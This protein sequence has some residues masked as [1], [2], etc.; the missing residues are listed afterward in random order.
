MRKGNYEE[1]WT[2][3]SGVGVYVW[4]QVLG[5]HRGRKRLWIGPVSLNPLAN[6]G[7]GP[8]VTQNVLALF[9]RVL[10]FLLSIHF[11][12]IPLLE[13]KNPL[14]SKVAFLLQS[15]KTLTRH[16]SCSYSPMFDLIAFPPLC[17]TAPPARL[18]QTVLEAGEEGNVILT[19]RRGDK[20]DLTHAHLAGFPMVLKG[21]GTGWLGIA[22]VMSLLPEVLGLKGPPQGKGKLESSQEY[23]N[24]IIIQVFF[25]LLALKLMS[26]LTKIQKWSF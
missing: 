20:V 15:R 8:P 21:L 17:A 1:T 4:P 6:S 26:S 25:S 9:W 7:I 2:R 19:V 14:K 18:W 3:G 23:I 10:F 12:S 11:L 5:R 24:I 22:K 13:E 16:L